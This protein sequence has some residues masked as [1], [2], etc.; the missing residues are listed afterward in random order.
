MTSTQTM[1]EET[2]YAISDSM[3]TEINVIDAINHVENVQD[4]MKQIV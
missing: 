4:H 3:E 2:V 1:M